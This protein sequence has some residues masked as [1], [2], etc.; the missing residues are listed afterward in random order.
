MVEPLPVFIIYPKNVLLIKTAPLAPGKDVPEG[1]P[2]SMG[3]KVFDDANVM[4][5]CIDANLWEKNV[6]EEAEK[7]A[8]LTRCKELYSILN[9]VS[10]LVSFI[11]KTLPRQLNISPQWLAQLLFKK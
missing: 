2:T 4:K 11:I 8:R 9:E 1:T 6:E 3:F 7:A 5:C 10:Y